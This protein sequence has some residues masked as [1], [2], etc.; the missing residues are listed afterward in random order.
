MARAKP[1]WEP[2]SP[3]ATSGRGSPLKVVTGGTTTNVARVKKSIRVTN[4]I[5]HIISAVFTPPGGHK[6][7]E[8]ARYRDKGCRI[9]YIQR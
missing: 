4:G 1:S 9:D 8:A 2:T 7:V 6:A 3:P 5:V